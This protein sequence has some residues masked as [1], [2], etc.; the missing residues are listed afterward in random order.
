MIDF[1][2]TLSKSHDVMIHLIYMFQDADMYSDRHA[3]IVPPSMDLG[4]RVHHVPFTDSFA[5]SMCY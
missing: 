2:C 4:N 1:L 5:S 3:L